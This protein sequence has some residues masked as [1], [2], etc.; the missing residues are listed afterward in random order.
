MPRKGKKKVQAMEDD[1]N[2]EVVTRVENIYEY[3]KPLTGVDPESRCG[4][5]YKMIKDHTIPGACL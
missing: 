1:S 3:T 2:V 4:Q 5:V